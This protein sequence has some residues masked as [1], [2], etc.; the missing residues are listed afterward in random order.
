MVE[1]L[2]GALI[3]GGL[4]AG[5]LPVLGKLAMR[6]HGELSDLDQM[7]IV[8]DIRYILSDTESRT[9]TFYG[10]NPLTMD[11]GVVHAISVNKDQYVR[12]KYSIFDIVSKTPQY[13]YSRRQRRRYYPRSLYNSRMSG[14]AAPGSYCRF[15]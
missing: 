13:L 12:T 14:K 1:L 7:R 4:A 10:Q 6:G 2:I 15:C 5:I 3:L 9:E 8:D 11:E